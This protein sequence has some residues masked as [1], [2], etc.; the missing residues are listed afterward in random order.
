MHHFKCVSVFFLFAHPITSIIPGISAQMSTTSFCLYMGV[1]PSPAISYEPVQ[2]RSKVQREDYPR[3]NGEGWH[4]AYETASA[5][6]WS[7]SGLLW[8]EF[9]VESLAYLASASSFRLNYD[10]FTS[11]STFSLHVLNSLCQSNYDIF[12]SLGEWQI[13]LHMLYHAKSFFQPSL[14]FC[15]VWFLSWKPF[16]RLK[17]VKT[18]LLK[19]YC[20]QIKKKKNCVWVI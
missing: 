16:Y 20:L 7:R 6:L 12:F 10:S 3:S 19:K 18:L 2:R 8:G 15:R 1:K 17:I 9:I 4:A 14:C 11:F 5:T 13:D